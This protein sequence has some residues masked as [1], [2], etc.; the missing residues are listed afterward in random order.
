MQEERSVGLINEQELQCHCRTDA[1][2][3][4]NIRK[5]SYTTVNNKSNLK[6]TGVLHMKENINSM[7]EGTQNMFDICHIE[8]ELN[9]NRNRN[10]QTAV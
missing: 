1:I 7:K 10:T 8:T 4:I 9:M 6:N 3:P 5:A 2:D